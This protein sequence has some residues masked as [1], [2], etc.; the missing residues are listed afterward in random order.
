MT[1]SN[2]NV[3]MTSAKRCGPDTRCLGRHPA[4]EP[5]CE[6]NDWVQVCSRYRAHRQDGGDESACR[7]H[8]VL[9]EL[10]TDVPGRQMRCGDAGPDDGSNKKPSPDTLSERLPGKR[11]THP[12]Q[13]DDVV[14]P[15]RSGRVAQHAAPDFGSELSCPASI[16]ASERTV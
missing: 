7:C 16:S 12:Q 13:Q 8:G 3:A 5:I 10:Q 1:S 14:D 15:A 9:K 4:V 11:V 2:P 6:G